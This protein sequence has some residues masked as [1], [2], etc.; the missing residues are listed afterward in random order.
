MSFVGFVAAMKDGQEIAADG[1]RRKA[2]VLDFLG[3]P[4]GGVW[5]FRVRSAVIFPEDLDYDTLSIFDKA[6]GGRQL[7]LVKPQ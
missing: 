6:V 1:Y 2:V 7:L 5:Q 3:P 4:R